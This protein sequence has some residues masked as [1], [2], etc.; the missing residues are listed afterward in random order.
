MR[1]EW[2]VKLSVTFHFNDKM[3]GLAANQAYKMKDS[4][5]VTIHID[6]GKDLCYNW[7]SLGAFI[8]V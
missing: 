6:K 7:D 4:M 3:N 1:T 5:A 8:N 2:S